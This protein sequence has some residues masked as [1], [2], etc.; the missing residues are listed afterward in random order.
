M[1]DNMKKSK[2]FTVIC[3]AA[4]LLAA[5]SQDE[6]TNADTLPA[7]RYPLQI[8]GIEVTAEANGQPW[9]RVT[10][11]ADGTSGDWDWDGTEKI[12]VQICSDGGTT[13]Y[14]LNS[15]KQIT[16]EAP[17]FWQSTSET[18]INAWYP[19]LD[20]T[21]DLA[22]QSTKLAY[23]LKG[24]GSG[25]YQNPVSLTF[26]HQLA[27]VRVKLTGD[28]TTDVHYVSVKGFTKCTSTKGDISGGT[29]DGYILMKKPSGNGGYWEANV[30]PQTSVSGT[31]L[32]KLN[33]TAVT[34]GAG[35][36]EFAAGSY[37]TITISLQ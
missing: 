12:G 10:E 2:L 13:T 33:D 3:L 14:T 8:A 9:A 21:I 35:I 27:K 1:N 30:V 11:G 6:G 37:Y 15:G 24:T 16:S 19:S 5:C 4:G 20:G 17:L 18:G 26:T 29:D 28:K 25:D 23:V 32:I 7:G 22:D 31:E 34:I 36:T